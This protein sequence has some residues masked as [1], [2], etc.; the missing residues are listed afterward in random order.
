MPTTGTEGHWDRRLRRRVCRSAT[1]PAKQRW[2]SGCHS[3]RQIGVCKGSECVS[4]FS[5]ATHAHTH[6]HTLSQPVTQYLNQETRSHLHSQ[7]LTH[8][9]SETSATNSAT[10]MLR[11]SWEPKHLPRDACCYES[12]FSQFYL[13]PETK[14][15]V[16]VIFYMSHDHFLR[17]ALILITR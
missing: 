13:V 3:G 10:R 16:L 1:G 12:W 4:Q 6:T 2:L 7:S 17:R 9:N 11:S 8:S 14:F 15:R 5:E